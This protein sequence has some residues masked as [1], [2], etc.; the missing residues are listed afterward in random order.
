MP[1]SVLA[2]PRANEASAHSLLE[3]SLQELHLLLNSLTQGLDEMM[4]MEGDKEI[5]RFQASVFLFSTWGLF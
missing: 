2:L 4:K 1:D 5:H 3:F